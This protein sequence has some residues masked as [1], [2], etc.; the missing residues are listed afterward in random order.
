MG[1]PVTGIAKSAYVNSFFE[2]ERLPYEL[3]WT[4]PVAQTNFPSLALL[5]PRI[6]AAAN[7]PELELSDFS[8]SALKLAFG[9]Q[10]LPGTTG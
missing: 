6:L 1:D 7:D 3:G 4:P 9:G 10:G 5:I 8:I 2:Q